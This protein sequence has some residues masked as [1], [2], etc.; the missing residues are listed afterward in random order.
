MVNAEKI[1]A[2][3][4]E[5]PYKTRRRELA[6]AKKTADWQQRQRLRNAVEVAHATRLVKI[7]ELVA[8]FAVIEGQGLA[9]SVLQKMTRILTEQ[10]V[11]EA[12]AKVASQRTAIL[13]TFRASVAAARERNRADL[14][15]LLRA[16]ALHENKGQPTQARALYADNLGAEPDWPDALH[17]FIRFLVNQGDEAR[18]R[19]TQEEARRDYDEAR[20]LALRLTALDPGNTE[21]QRDLSVSYE[22]L[23]DVAVAQG[24]LDEAAR[25]YGDGLAIA[26]KLAAGDP[27]NTGWQRDLSVSFFKISKLKAQQKNWPDAIS[28]A[29][30]SL[31]IHELLS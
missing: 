14:Q 22:R 5:T 11:N 29:E 25:A 31:K 16:V 30:A 3:L 15:L 18:V 13:Q 21:W 28:N 23:G 26:K 1:C 17:D 6:D 10:G 9:T 27:G 19:T 20:R 4:R 12:I 8:L 7:N 2:H 24:K